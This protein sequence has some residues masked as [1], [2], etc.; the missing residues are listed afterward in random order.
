MLVG[1]DD[2]SGF[3]HGTGQTLVACK[4]VIPAAINPYLREPKCTS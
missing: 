4:R 3:M 2:R 1:G